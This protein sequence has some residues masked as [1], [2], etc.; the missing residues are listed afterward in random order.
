[1]PADSSGRRLKV[2]AA[3]LHELGAKCEKLGTELFAEAAAS[4][5]ATSPWQSNAG[6]VDIAVAGARKDM[7][8][9][10]KQIDTRAANYSRA[11]AEYTATEADSAALF[12]RLV[13]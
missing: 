4:F 10:A 13:P 9:L 6:T 12:R 5:V 8:E 7:A 2:L 1:M 3:G 11:G